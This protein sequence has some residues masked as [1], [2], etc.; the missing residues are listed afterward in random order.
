MRKLTIEPQ[1]RA[2]AG[3]MRRGHVL[4]SESRWETRIWLRSEARMVAFTLVE[5]IVAISILA[6]MAALLLPAMGKARTRASSNVCMS[7]L[8]QI[9]ICWMIYLDDHD[10]ALPLN[11][12]APTGGVWRSTS[13]SWIGDSSA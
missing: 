3:G 11:N 13:D 5:V 12:A 7:N 4:V 1:T 8:R 10:G 9:Q 2:A 6:L